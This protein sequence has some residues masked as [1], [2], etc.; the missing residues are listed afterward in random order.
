MII[1]ETPL[2]HNKNIV[3]NERQCANLKYYR[4]KIVNGIAVEFLAHVHLKYKTD[5]YNE[6][7]R[8]LSH[9][10]TI[11]LSSQWKFNV[12]LY[13]GLFSK[14]IYI[15]YIIYN[16]LFIHYLRLVNTRRSFIDIVWLTLFC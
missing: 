15:Y 12:F 2:K 11:E 1:N 7:S 6:W 9:S 16:M 10:A 4:T 14:N 13:E 3:C 5:N 8:I